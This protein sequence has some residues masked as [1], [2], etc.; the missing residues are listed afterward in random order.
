MKIA[1]DPA[2]CDGFGFCAGILAG[3]VSLD[4]W[5]FPLLSQASVPDELRAAARQ[6][7]KC[8]PRRALLLSE[9]RRLTEDRPRRRRRAA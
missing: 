3:L 4:E 1:V 6:A 5:G 8:C 7:V 9:D 2:A